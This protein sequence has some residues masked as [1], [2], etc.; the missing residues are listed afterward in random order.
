MCHFILLIVWV[1]SFSMMLPYIKFA[2]DKVLVFVILH[3][4]CENSA[5]VSLTLIL[6]LISRAG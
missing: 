4:K 2:Q 5:T 3:E 6:T 1:R